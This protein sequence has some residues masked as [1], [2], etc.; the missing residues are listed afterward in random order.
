MGPLER[1]TR[2]LACGNRPMI[3]SRDPLAFGPGAFF[4]FR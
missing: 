4:Y 2:Q 3:K 1:V